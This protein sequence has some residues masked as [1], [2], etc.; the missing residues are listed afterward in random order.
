MTRWSSVC[1]VFGGTF[2]PPH[3]GHR[4]AVEGLFKHPGVGRVRI[5]PAA[6]PPGKT[7]LVQTED[8]VKMTELCFEGL[9]V[10]I[11]L[12]EIVRAEKSLSPSYT[13]DTLLELRPEESHLAFVMG[14]DQFAQFDKWHRF[15]EIVGLAHWIVLKRKGI[16]NQVIDNALQKFKH[17][18][19]LERGPESQSFRLKNTDKL[20]Y[21]VE[22]DAPELSS[23]AIREQIALKGEPPEGVLHPKVSAYLN[24][25]GLYGSQK[26]R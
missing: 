12:R 9:P 17:L 20:L 8:R 5:I 22:T 24:E 15:S 10:T 21:L 11:D 26:N 1:A 7:P 6:N 4:I 2:N 23:T 14:T 16:T 25:R 3:I 19:I 13:I 18:G